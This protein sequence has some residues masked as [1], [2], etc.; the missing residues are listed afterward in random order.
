MW[1]KG[2]TGSSES[3]NGQ[4]KGS[5]DLHHRKN[6]ENR[7]LGKEE[8][9]KK[10]QYDGFSEY[11]ESGDHSRKEKNKFCKHETN[12]ER[13]PLSQGY[14]TT[15]FSSK[16]EKKSCGMDLL[17]KSYQDFHLFESYKQSLRVTD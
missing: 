15:T 8:V 3:S 2:Y 1:D 16:K 10:E 14:H 17:E 7:V 13:E 5:A 12:N 11:K 6:V 9:G 4:L